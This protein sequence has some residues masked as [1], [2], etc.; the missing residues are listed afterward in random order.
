MQLKSGQLF[1][2]AA[3]IFLS[4]A[5]FQR[6]SVWQTEISVWQDA[7]DKALYKVRPHNNLGNALRDD[8]NLPEKAI[9]EYTMAI[10][11]APGEVPPRHNIAV[12]YLMLA[13]YDEAERELLMGIRLMPNNPVLHANLGFVYLKKGM[14]NRAGDEFTTALILRPD[15]QMARDN[16]LWIERMAPG[17]RGN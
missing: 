15:Y 9:L 14:W 16:L 1:F 10:A 17:A 6:N 7:R 5:A 4:I 13:K 11:L 3:A 8:A 12:A 2:I